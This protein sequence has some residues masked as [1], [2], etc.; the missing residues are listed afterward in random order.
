MDQSLIYPYL[1]EPLEVEAIWGGHALAREYGKKADPKVKVGESWECWDKNVVA[2]GPLQGSSIAELRERLGGTLLGDLDPTQMFPI[3]TK[4][5]DARGSLSVQ[6]HPD[7][8]YAQRVEHQANG[9]TES[10]FI[11]GAEPGAELILG[12]ARDTDREEYLRRVAEGSLA[13]ILRRVPVQ[14]GDAFYLP[15]GTLHAIGAGIIL[16]ETQQASDLTYRIFD[17]NR[18]D[19]NGKPRALH[20]DRAADVLDWKRSTA[21]A[22]SEL[23]YVYDGLARTALIADRRFVVERIALKPEV[24]YVSTDGRPLVIMALDQRIELECNGVPSSVK[25]YQTV[26]IPAAAKRL[27]ISGTPS[28]NILLATPL[29]SNSL[30]HRLESVN[31]NSRVITRFMAQF[32]PAT[33][34]ETSRR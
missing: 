26:L 18:V 31:I 9:K 14:P 21:G 30:E 33:G 17:W 6:V 32:T 1:I 12:W 25:P 24:R 3:L 10:W 11:L 5:I 16:F 28:A 20:A 8:A 27:A 13:D 7:D 29:G 23:S 4:I 15:A 34:M 22:I 2:N 19:A